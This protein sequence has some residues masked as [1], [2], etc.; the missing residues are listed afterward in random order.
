MEKSNAIYSWNSPAF[1]LK[2]TKVTFYFLQN[3]RIFTLQILVAV[4]VEKK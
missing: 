3:K 1:I 4:S 2:K